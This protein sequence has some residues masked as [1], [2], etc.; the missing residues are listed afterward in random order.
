M[1]AKWILEYQ[2]KK[3]LNLKA[4]RGE[5]ESNFK[6]SPDIM[7]TTQGIYFDITDGIILNGIRFSRQNKNGNFQNILRADR[8][9]LEFSILNY[10]QRKPVLTSIRLQSGDWLVPI[11]NENTFFELFDKLI[12]L[13]DSDRN[14]KSPLAAYFIPKPELFLNNIHFNLNHDNKYNSLD[15]NLNSIFVDFKL[16]KDLDQIKIEF[17]IRKDGANY[18]NYILQA[19]GSWTDNKQIKIRFELNKISLI[20]LFTLIQKSPVIPKQSMTDLDWLQ[21]SNGNLSG[22]G[23]IETYGDG[24]GFNLETLIH[25][26]DVD[27]FLSDRKFLELKTDSIELK[28]NSGWLKNQQLAFLKTKLENSDFYFTADYKN[29]GVHPNSIAKN[30]NNARTKINTRFSMN[31][32]SGVKIIGLQ[33]KGQVNLSLLV[34]H[35]KRYSHTIPQIQFNARNLET[36][37]IIHTTNSESIKISSLN[38][39]VSKDRNIPAILK[40]NSRIGEAEVTIEADG[41]FKIYR[42]RDSISMAPDMNFQIVSKNISY[43]DLL[44][45]I[46][47]TH[48]KIIYNGS[49]QEAPRA[50]DKGPLWEEKFLQSDFYITYIHDTKLKFDVILENLRPASNL[51]ES[52]KLSGELNQGLA[53]LKLDKVQCEKCDLRFLYKLNMQRSIPRHDIQVTISNPENKYPFSLFTGSKNA[54]S[55]YRF[56]YFMAGDGWL[57]GDILHRSFSRFE[58][59]AQN[60]T[61]SSPRIVKLLAYGTGLNTPNFLLSSIRLKYGTEGPRVQYYLDA[62]H[63]NSARISSQ[64]SYKTGSPGF[65]HLK[66]LNNP[67]GSNRNLYIKFK[68]DNSWTPVIQ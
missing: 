62:T 61:L 11:E 53:E 19:R 22:K 8:L 33:K 60:V 10:F 52:L 17:K 13:I 49:R 41:Q 25:D 31:N 28:Y 63:S 50:E 54:P 26:L 16:K 29:P 20:Q 66:F 55:A 3:S 15:A 44:N 18:S 57:A 47:N 24:I 48:N 30:K 43:K 42:Y 46:W 4:I 7:L 64:A 56:Q 65:G 6:N 39:E 2:I 36:N 38:F 1:P 12:L 51:P 58:L 5:L 23:S 67:D 21:F 37:K 40:T 45:M 34:D 59:T 35:P 27:I 68:P 32:T 9:I 14:P